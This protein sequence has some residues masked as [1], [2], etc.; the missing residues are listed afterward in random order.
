MAAGQSLTGALKLLFGSGDDSNQIANEWFA[1][2]CKN[3]SNGPSIGASVTNLLE[4]FKS[5]RSDLFEGGMPLAVLL[6]S[7]QV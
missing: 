2:F 4:D 7:V 5:V 1:N 6:E 3:R